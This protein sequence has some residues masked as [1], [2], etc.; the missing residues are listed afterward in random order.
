MLSAST[1]KEVPK[2]FYHEITRKAG[3]GEELPF[4]HIYLNSGAAG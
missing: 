2:Q 1:T 3:I 4:W